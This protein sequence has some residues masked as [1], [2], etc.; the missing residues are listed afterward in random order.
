MTTSFTPVSDAPLSRIPFTARAEAS[1]LELSKWM[2]ISGVIG[3]VASVLKLCVALFIGHGLG[4][5]IG[6]VVTFLVGYWSYQAGNAFGSMASSDSADQRYLMD[7]FGLLR[8]VFLLQAA[9][10]LL[11]FGL[12]GAA[13]VGSIIVAATR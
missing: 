2:H 13:I 5:Y 11:A 9:M 1:I 3:I 8:R 6:A 7:G 4:A 12:F 10:I